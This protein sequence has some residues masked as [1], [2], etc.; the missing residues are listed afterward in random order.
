MS[1]HLPS[2]VTRRLWL[3]PAIGVA[4]LAA[5]VWQPHSPE[6]IALGLRHAGPSLVHPLG[7]DHLGRDLLSRLMV[8]GARTAL[9][10]ALVSASWVAIGTFM[11]LAAAALRGPF[12]AAL[13]R[14]AEFFAVLPSLLAAIVVTS[15]IGL[16]P[17]SAG[18]ALGLAGW[19][20]FAL[21]TYGLARRGLTEPYV[22]AA[23][24]LGG[25]SPSL[26]RRH[27]WPA[28][29][30]TQLSYLGTKLGRVAIA[31]AALAFLGLGA[32]T[33]RA[34]WGA[35]MYEYRLFALD[36][37]L[38][39]IAPGTAL[40][41]LCVALRV[42]IGGDNGERVPATSGD[43]ASAVA[44]AVEVQDVKG[45]SHAHGAGA[46]MAGADRPAI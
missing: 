5:A 10:V 8:G 26:L 43:L 30:E 29:W 40:M 45:Y 17:V 3:L 32:D 23:R 38:L 1:H 9:V 36:H 27:V 31:Y 4:A 39:I 14:V 11:G 13:L 25:S 12:S 44:R 15:I 34:D 2:C 19:G 35:M 37:P 24:A 7:T 22:L 41:A 18:L 46:G 33:A 20:P 6:A 21:L 16:G 42:A 28:M